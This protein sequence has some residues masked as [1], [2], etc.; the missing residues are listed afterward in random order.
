[1][2][3]VKELLKSKKFWAALIGVVMIVV[4]EYAPDFP[5]N[6]DQISNI[7]YLLIAY[8]MGSGLE[9]GLKEMKGKV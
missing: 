3:K 6:E 5:L 2:E 8:I 4:K 1:M 9:A 7:V